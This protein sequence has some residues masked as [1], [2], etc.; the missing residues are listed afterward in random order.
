MLVRFIFF[1]L[2]FG[3]YL[4][5]NAQFCTQAQSLGGPAGD[6]SKSIIKIGQNVLVTGI[7]QQEITLGT[8]SYTSAGGSDIFFT[9]QNDLG[10]TL[11]SASIGNAQNNDVNAVCS[12]SSGNFY[13]S[14]TFAGQLQIGSN[15]LFNNLN[16][17]F[18]AKYNSMGQ[19]QWLKQFQP[20]GIVHVLDMQV[21]PDGQ[22]LWIS[23][24]YNDSLVFEN[25]A[26]F[27]G[28][29][30][31]LFVSK[32]ETSN[33]NVLWMS[34]APYAKWAKAKT[35]TPLPNG[36]AWLAVEFRDSLQM[37]GLTYYHSPSHV[38][39]LMSQIDAQGN[40]LRH[41]R[42]GGVYDD[43]PKKM[44]LSPDANSIWLCGDFVAVL[45]VDSFT[46]MTAFRYY[47]VFWVKMNLE[48]EALAVGQTNTIANAYVFDLAY[49]DDKVWLGGYFQDSLQGISMHYTN[50]GFDIFW[51][52]IDTLTANFTESKVA[53]GSGNDQIWG[54]CSAFD[55]LISTGT[56][57]QQMSMHG[58]LLT[59]SGFSDAWYSCSEQILNNTESIPE[60]IEVKIIPNPTN[61]KFRV[62]LSN[63][64]GLEWGLYAMNGKQVMSGK[65]P[66]ID[67]SKLPK[68]IYSLRVSNADGFAFA[69][70]VLKD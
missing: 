34:D 64:E 41:K 65:N 69:K 36:S 54:L 26:V 37:P 16:T 63:Y 66:E 57:Q 40:W 14:G 35:L 9:A 59:A 51:L 18:I 8:N 13:L 56:F 5:T 62:E 52:G 11:F 55:A 22:Y 43:E 21:S 7:Y 46:L 38:D 30:Y 2:F 23:G 3:H 10:Q 60:L 49:H 29:A 53:G 68:A 39:I 47:D 67:A 17:C 12:D 24:D 28:N 31:N 50:G 15:S 32:M 42:W 45:N 4:V 27:C 70:I 33:G 44:R 1:S 48:G 6:A 20:Q 25:E 61:G 58:N 19:V